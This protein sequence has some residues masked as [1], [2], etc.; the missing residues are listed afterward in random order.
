MGP[1]WAFTTPNVVAGIQ[2]T[3]QPD[4]RGSADFGMWYKLPQ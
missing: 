1:E 4:P 3:G 2:V